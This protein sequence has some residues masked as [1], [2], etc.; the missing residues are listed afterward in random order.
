MK[1]WSVTHSLLLIR[2]DVVRLDFQEKEKCFITH[3]L[4]VMGWETW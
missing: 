2:G 1:K 3:F 4:L